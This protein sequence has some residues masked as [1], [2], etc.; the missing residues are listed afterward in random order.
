M[1]SKSKENLINIHVA[2]NVSK[3]ITDD[4]ENKNNFL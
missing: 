3:M 1:S 2:S 4:D